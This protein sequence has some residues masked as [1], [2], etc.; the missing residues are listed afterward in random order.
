VRLAD[1]ALVTDGEFVPALGPAARQDS[2]PIGRFHT[3][4]ES[5]GFRAMAIIRL[6]S[7]FWHDSSF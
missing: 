2:A 6:K 5:M 4:A 1:G 7:T 3:L